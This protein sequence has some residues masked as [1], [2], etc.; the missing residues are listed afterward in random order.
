MGIIIS[1]VSYVFLEAYAQAAAS[2]AYIR[3]I[4]CVTCQLVYSSF[5]VG[6][7]VVASARFI[8][9]GYGVA[10]FICYSDVCVSEYVNN[11]AYLRGKVCECYPLLCFC[12]RV[13][14]CVLFCVLSDVLVYVLLW[15]G[16]RFVG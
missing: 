7:D 14:W 8:Q 9:V 2:L 15:V 3:Q 1:N 16:T 11:L 5:T 13:V 4:T 12:C 10:A 6:R